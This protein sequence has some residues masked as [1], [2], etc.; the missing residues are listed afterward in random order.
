MGPKGGRV[1]SEKQAANFISK[2]SPAAL[3]IHGD[4]CIYVFTCY[5]GA[6]RSGSL[7][8]QMTAACVQVGQT[9]ALPFGAGEVCI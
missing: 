7:I 2:L 9:F 5:R 4:V 1:F 6:L 8:M 3:N